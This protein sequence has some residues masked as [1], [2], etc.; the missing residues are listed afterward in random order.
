MKN[1]KLIK[2]LD[3]GEGE[4]VKMVVRRY[5]LIYW[6][7][8]LLVLILLLLPFFL[9]FPLFQWE[10]WGPAIFA[11]LLSIGILG[12]LRLYILLYFNCLVVTNRRLVDFDQRGPLDR[13]VSE[14][15]LERID[16]LNYRRKGIFQ[17]LLN[18][19]TLQY[20]IPPGRAK[21]LVKGVRNPQAVCQ[22]IISIIEEVKQQ[23]PQQPVSTVEGLKEILQQMKEEVGEEG[24]K[25]IIK[26]IK[27]PR[28]KPK[29]QSRDKEVEE[30]WQKED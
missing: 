10:M 26:D 17:T 11:I 25:K 16:D 15:G 22:K 27:D 4:E 14:A 24:F 1:K 23:E 28:E 18:Y 7:Q 2:N 30:F 19:G 6:W 5:P 20:S 29:P 12:L 9:L 3:L 21:I 8:I 13:T